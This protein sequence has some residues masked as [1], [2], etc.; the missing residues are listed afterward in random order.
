MRLSTQHG[1]GD[2]LTLSEV[3]A[4]ALGTTLHFRT[5]RV[6]YLGVRRWDSG[7]DCGTWAGLTLFEALSLL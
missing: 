6:L 4:A 3:M 1:P 5:L 7:P 2:P